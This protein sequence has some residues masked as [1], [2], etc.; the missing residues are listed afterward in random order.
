MVRLLLLCGVVL[1][2]RGVEGCQSRSGDDGERINSH[3]VGRDHGQ[4]E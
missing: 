4:G 1:V 2:L 3:Q